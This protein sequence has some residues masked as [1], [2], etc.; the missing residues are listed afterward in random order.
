[1]SRIFF[2]SDTHFGHGNIIKYCKRPFLAEADKQALSRDGAWRDGVWKDERTYWRMSEDAV[3]MMNND[4]IDN[5]NALVGEDD[6]LWHLGD[7]AFAP[8]SDYYRHCRNYR[9][10]IKCRNVSLI[11]G[12][13]DQRSIRDLFDQ[14]Y[15]DYELYVGNQRIILHHYAKATWNKAHRGNWQLYGHSHAGAEPWMDKHMPGRR[16]MDVGVDNAYLLVGKFRPF[17][18]EELKVIMDKRPGF[19]MDHHI[20]KGSNVPDD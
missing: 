5:I 14:T 1:M 18:Y 7:W 9:D 12:N 2:T 15:D 17:S 3:W 16:S 11:W 13:H 4:I 6:I 10:K 8:K 20:G 19:S